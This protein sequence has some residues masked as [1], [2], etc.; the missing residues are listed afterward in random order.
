MN[1]RKI[2]ST[3]LILVISFG[4]P[5]LQA[6]QYSFLFAVSTHVPFEPETV[7][8]LQMLVNKA[9]TEHKKIAV[10][11]AGKSMGGQTGPATNYDYRISLKKLNKLVQLDVQKKEVTVQTGMTWKELQQF[12]ASH[13]L[14]IK[15][16][17]SYHDFAIGGSLS[18]NVHGQALHHAPIISTVLSCKI[19]LANGN[20]VTASR[21]ENKELFTSA[22]GGYGLLGI[23]TEVTLSLTEDVLLERKVALIDAKNLS[24]YFL[25]HVQTNPNVEFY[26]ARFF[27]T[28]NQLLKKAFIITYEKTSSTNAE[29]F[30]LTQ[31]TKS[32]F[33]KNILRLSAH[34]NQFK[35][36]RSP[37]E[38]IYLARQEIISRNNFTNITIE[39]LPADNHNTQY[40]LQEYFIP[41]ENLDSFLNYLANIIK[42]NSINMLN[43][44]ARHVHQDVETKLSFAHTDCCALVLYVSL[45]KDEASYASTAHWTKQLIDA[46]LVCK[47]TY[48]LP[49]Q[50]LADQQQFETA[51]PC[52]KEFVEIKK[53][54]DPQE[55][56]V[57]QLYVKYGLS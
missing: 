44:T 48:Y 52:F 33:Q 15:A 10:V 24:H 25:N 30:K 27:I 47:G 6:E 38:K 16:M 40:I 32:N 8:Q 14:A 20:I 13:G 3:L 35:K 7:E 41:Y 39:S 45:D 9:R 42:S 1:L 17:Q 53:V 19:L 21:T 12:I 55:M 5:H 37:L 18:V 26:S 29:Y 46:A 50:L 31:N 4:T 36:L 11:G 28:P 49:Y 54:Y 34:Y 57:N 22:I 56:F 2:F 23:V 51:Y 43:V